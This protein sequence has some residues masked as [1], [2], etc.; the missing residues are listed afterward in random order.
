MSASTAAEKKVRAHAEAKA[1]AERRI[2]ELQAKVPAADD[3]GDVGKVLDA[4]ADVKRAEQERDELTLRLDAAV[5]A[6]AEAVAEEKARTEDER[7]SLARKALDSLA[8]SLT[9]DLVSFGKKLAAHEA[10]ANSLP[11]EARFKY[12]PAAYCET[13]SRSICTAADMARPGGVAQVDLR[14]LIPTKP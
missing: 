1:R 13:A 8:V 12:W 9:S 5:T 14:L 7:C 10:L 6:Y 4:R 11:G 2:V 3:P